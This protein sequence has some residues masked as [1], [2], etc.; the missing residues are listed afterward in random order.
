MTNV[1]ADRDTAEKE[2]EVGNGAFQSS[3]YD[4]ALTCYTKAINV[5]SPHLNNFD[6]WGQRLIPENV[7]KEMEAQYCR[8]LSNRAA[9]YLKIGSTLEALQ[10]CNQVIAI[11]PQHEKALLRRAL[12]QE[13]LGRFDDALENAVRLLEKLEWGSPIHARVLQVKQRVERF[14][15]ARQRRNDS[16]EP[17]PLHLCNSAQTLRLNFNTP[18]PAA[19]GLGSYFPVHVFVA[20]EFGLFN[21]ADLDQDPALGPSVPLSVTLTSTF[22]GNFGAPVALEARHPHELCLDRHG[23]ASFQIR[24]VWRTLPQVPLPAPHPQDALP[25]PDTLKENE[26]E[27]VAS[28]QVALEDGHLLGGRAVLPIV[29]LPIR[30][31]RAGA[32]TDSFNPGLG[33]FFSCRSLRLPGL[34][35]PVLIGE[36]PDHGIPGKVWD[37]GLVLA[38]FMAANSALV[39]DRACV[40]LGAGTGI[41]GITAACYGAGSL[42]LTDLPEQRRWA[43]LH[44]GGTA[45]SPTY[46]GRHHLAHV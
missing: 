15:S 29:S 23:R 40:E 42:L 25:Q 44:P 46:N 11:D 3:N 37:G 24:F 1:K 17:T 12:A 45:R 36:A 38:H 2:N 39:R 9:A 5:I 22:G 43:P 32:A 8:C 20:N 30:I 7:V 18:A 28:I 16:P 26:E 6:Q 41:V 4:H 34:P 14:T 10:D 19:V 21:R 35:G 27:E 33:G 31:R 13:A